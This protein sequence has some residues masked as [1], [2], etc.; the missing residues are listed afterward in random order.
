MKISHSNNYQIYGPDDINHSVEPNLSWREPVILG[1]VWTTIQL[2]AVC[3][4]IVK[5]TVY[6]GPDADQRQEAIPENESIMG[7]FNNSD[8]DNT[9]QLQMLRE[10]DDSYDY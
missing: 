5:K 3:L 4:F 7:S 6:S 9:V 10:D 8:N 1:L 2:L